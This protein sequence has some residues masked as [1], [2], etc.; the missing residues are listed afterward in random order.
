MKETKAAPLD[1]DVRIGPADETVV[2]FLDLQLQYAT[3]RE[4]VLEA[5]TKVCDGQ[6]FILGPE[7]EAF[8]REI[9]NLLG[10]N[11]AIGVSSGTDA[12]LLA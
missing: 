10:V 8:E 5:I 2:P 3:I 1:D 6:R 4:K 12:L 9:A 7:V 11:H